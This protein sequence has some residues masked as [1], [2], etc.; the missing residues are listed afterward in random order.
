[1]MLSYCSVI[2][3]TAVLVV[4]PLSAA[5]AQENQIVHDAEYYIISAQNGERW[6]AEDDALDARLTELREKY[7]RPPNI[8][9]VLVDG[10]HLVCQ[11]VVTSFI[12]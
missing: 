4:M 10:W 8:V 3:F 6:A 2:G 1:M 9:F 7:G 11:S 12:T 5:A